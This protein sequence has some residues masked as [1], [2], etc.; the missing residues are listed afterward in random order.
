MAFV[1]LQEAAMFEFETLPAI[2]INSQ[3]QSWTIEGWKKRESSKANNYSHL[4]SHLN[5]TIEGW[6]KRKKRIEKIQSFKV[7]HSRRKRTLVYCG[8]FWG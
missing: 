5:L 4:C 7:S 1:E 2:V 8:V 3:E 6:K